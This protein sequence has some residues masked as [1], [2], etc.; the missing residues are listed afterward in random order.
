MLVYIDIIIRVFMKKTDVGYFREDYDK[1]SMDE[2]KMMR[3]RLS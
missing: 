3:M 2:M 1:M